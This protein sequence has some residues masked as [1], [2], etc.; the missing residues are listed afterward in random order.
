MLKSKIIACLAAVVLL[1]AC[2]P[3][4]D[5][6]LYDTLMDDL[7]PSP[8][9]Q[10]QE[11]EQRRLTVSSVGFDNPAT[12][13]L[14]NHTLAYMALHPDV[15]I[16]L[17]ILDPF[18]PDINS[19]LAAALMAGSAADIVSFYPDINTVQFMNEGYFADIYDLMRADAAFNKEDYFMNILSAVETDGKLFGLCTD[20]YP[21]S[22]FM[23]KN[24]FPE[25]FVS[26]FEES[27]TL[28]YIDVL[29]MYVKMRGDAYLGDGVGLF[30]DYAPTNVFAFI[31]R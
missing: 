8:S 14:K 27:E 17:D 30:E 31:D 26:L 18:D 13:T 19:K 23:M 24:T 7:L 20:F 2:A 6:N 29:K 15:L 1:S 28:S 21:Y 3:S 5:E 11:G 9:I 4:A 22:L 25:E 16:A 10:T 12:N